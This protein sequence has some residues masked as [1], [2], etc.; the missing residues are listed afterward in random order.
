MICH[1]VL[2]LI[3]LL[4]AGLS[5]SVDSAPPEYRLLR[6]ETHPVPNPSSGRHSTDLSY[7]PAQPYA[8]G[9]FGAAPRKHWSRHFGYYRNYTQWSAK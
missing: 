9:W 4:A 7:G 1:R 5:G 3:G 6:I 8:Y 2:I